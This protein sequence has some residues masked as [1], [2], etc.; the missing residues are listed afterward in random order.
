M[1]GER[2]EKKNEGDDVPKLDDVRV[3]IRRRDPLI[4]NVP[5]A[6]YV[7]VVLKRWDY[8]PRLVCQS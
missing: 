1:F 4:L 7:K 8:K 5:R 6:A 2:V 3:V